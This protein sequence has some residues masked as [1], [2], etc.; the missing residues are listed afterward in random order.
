MVV[1]DLIA[2]ASAGKTG[3]DRLQNWIDENRDIEAFDAFQ[4]RFINTLE[5]ALETELANDRHEFLNQ[6][7]KNRRKILEELPDLRVSNRQ[8]RIDTFCDTMTEVILEELEH[9]NIDEETLR[10]AVEAAYREALEKFVQEAQSDDQRLLLDMAS[11]L[12]TD[13]DELQEAL[14]EF[15]SNLKER[16]ELTGRHQRFRLLYPP[17]DESWVDELAFE[18]E[19]QHERRELPFLEPEGFD[20]IAGSQSERVLLAG[21]KGAGKSR[22]LVEGVAELGTTTDFSRVVVVTERM[23]KTEDLAKA[24][25]DLDGDV[26]LV[27]DDLQQSVTDDKLDFEDAFTELE[28]RINETG[29]ELYVRATVRSENL[30]DVLPDNWSVNDLSGRRDSGAE[31]EQWTTFEGV[32]LPVLEDE[33]LEQFVEASLDFYDL[34]PDEERKTAFI[35]AVTERNPTPLYVTSVCDNADGYLSTSDIERLPTDAVESWNRAYNNLDSDNS[36]RQLLEALVI[37]DTLDVTSRQ[38]TVTCLYRHL[39]DNRGSNVLDRGEELGWIT[40]EKSGRRETRI[41][42]HDVRLEA[43]DFEMDQLQTRGLFLE[44]SDFLLDDRRVERL[45]GDIG[46]LLNARFA[47]HVFENRLGSHSVEDARRHFERAVELVDDDGSPEPHLMY[48]SFLEDRAESTEA[49]ATQYE[50]AIDKAPADGDVYRHFSRFLRSQDKHELAIEVYE[51][52]LDHTPG[53]R[54]LRRDFA[55]L[56]AEQGQ[57]DRA[58]EVYEDGLDHTPGDTELRWHFAKLLEGQDQTDRAIEVYEDGLDQTTGHTGLR[59]NFAELLAE[60]DQ[61]DRAIEVYEDGL[62]HTP[63]DTE[64]RWHFAKLLEG[65]DQTDRAIEVY[66]DGLDQTTG[67]T[68]LRRNFAEL[69]AE[70]DQTDR[71]IEVYEDGLDHTPGDTGLRRDFAELLAEQGELPHAM[72][73][74]NENKGLEDEELRK[75]FAGFLKERDLSEQAADVRS[76]NIEG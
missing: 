19:V 32:R 64:L 39:S 29:H 45:P 31:H 63:G 41:V 7:E 71:A 52:G 38:K 68:G 58:I 8:E 61:T 53:D 22:T 13:V 2:V 46:A 62:D 11:E 18:L 24:F 34:N 44:F 17:T 57:T 69:L 14:M 5:R 3:Y 49:V 27:F 20:T 74:Y 16:P 66:E 75:E 43:V 54:W 12:Q 42:I 30:D 37:L 35:E 15:K 4:Q 50:A 51:D 28:Q 59:R 10:R 25:R 26:L 23:A 40:V 47:Q 70:Q 48:A 21:R 60:Q 76:G 6:Y 72:R 67:H 33:R 55:E 65:Q 1:G 73:I 56:L 36:L 9:E